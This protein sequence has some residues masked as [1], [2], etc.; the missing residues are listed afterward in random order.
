MEASLRV[1]RCPLYVPVSDSGLKRILHLV[2]FA[3]SSFPVM[4]RQLVWRPDVVWVVE[5]TLAG[6]PAAWLVARMSGA[7]VWLHVQDFEVD[8]AFGMGLLR[9]GWLRRFALGFERVLMRRF[10]RVSTISASMRTRLLLKGVD[11][12]RVR[13]FPNWANVAEIFPLSWP[14]ELHKTLSISEGE[15]V[16]LYSGN[17]GQK[18]GLE[19]LIEAA[20]RMAVSMPALRFVLCG[21]GAA[22]THLQRMAVGLKNILWLPLQPLEQMN[23]LLN[24][25]DFH[26]LPQRA[27]ASDLVMPSKLTNMLASG[28]PVIATA[29]E[30][31]EVSRVVLGCGLVT[32]PGD[33]DALV[34]AIQQLAEDGELRASF[35]QAARAY[36]LQNLA[37]DA[38][39]R[40]FKADL[41]QLCR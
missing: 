19:L 41:E 18:Q 30:D 15:V 1:Y 31:T 22:K 34:T 36:A 5:P 37:K 13:N 4:I 33:V 6:A 8:M 20:Q 39:L 32:P 3:L 12:E 2:S 27:D 25:A 14:S 40:R 24:L 9:W 10:D 29:L 11:V 17:M 23:E 21:E 16:A 7:K 38:I 28:R 26:L 35:G